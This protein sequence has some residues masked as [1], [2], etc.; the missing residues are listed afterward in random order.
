MELA[1]R[2]HARF[3]GCRPWIGEKL[4]ADFA[5][6]AAAVELYGHASDTEAEFDGFENANVAAANPDVVATHLAIAKRQWEKV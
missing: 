2:S 6:G 3:T 5:K 1:F 4:A